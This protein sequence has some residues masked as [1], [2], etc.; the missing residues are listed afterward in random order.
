M[1]IRN[2]INTT[3]F[4]VNHPVN[5]GSKIGAML[6]FAKWQIGS[7]LV[8]GQVVY[9]WIN[10]VKLIV[11]PGETGLT[12][13]IYCGLHE[14]EDMSY[15][16]HVLNSEDLFVDVGANVGSYTLL[17]CGVKGARGY[18]FEPVPE[19]FSRLQENL[20]INRLDIKVRAFNMGLA[21]KDGVLSFTTEQ[22]CVNHVVTDEDKSG[23]CL[24]VEV[25]TLDTALEGESPCVIK[26]DVEGFEAQVISGAHMVLSNESLHSVVMELNGSE[27]RYGF[28]E[29]KLLK[30]M[31]DYGFSTYSYEPF[32]R[33]LTSLEGKNNQSGNTLF[34]RNESAISRR[35]K[36]A[37]KIKVGNVEI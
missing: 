26:I 17:A 11:R 1:K 13:N 8:P 34:I 10:E 6:R 27:S 24:Q 36:V 23:K 30:T 15:V 7:R 28:S 5:R 31:L 3:K 14:F 29:E 22:G 2:L 25:L 16:L 35:L 19:T 37:P 21:D 4:I 18:A 20:R 32:S 12:G 33:G 9:E